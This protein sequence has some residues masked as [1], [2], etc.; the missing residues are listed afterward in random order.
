[1]SDAGEETRFAVVPPCAADGFPQ[2]CPGWCEYADPPRQA[3]AALASPGVGSTLPGG[4]VLRGEIGRGGMG[5]VFV[6]STASG[7][8]VA[9]KVLA[10][11]LA[12]CRGAHLRFV[13]EARAMSRVDHPNVLRLLDA[14]E[15][16]PCSFFVMEL[17][18]GVDLRDFI[19]EAG[20]YG[21]P[22]RRALTLLEAVCAGVAAIH[23]AEVVH[24]DLKP[25][26]V[27]VDASGRVVICDFGLARPCAPPC[28]FPDGV[29]AGTP[30]FIAPE[31]AEGVQR[32]PR[33]S[34]D[35]Y[36]LGVI[37]YELLAGAP[38]FEADS[39]TQDRGLPHER[40]VLPPRALNSAIPRALDDALVA[41]LDHAP[42]R[43]PT[44]ADLLDI[45][46]GCAV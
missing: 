38:A 12:R 42:R 33:P 23:R 40:P 17:V 9:V 29:L 14:Q 13:G 22:L 11:D 24:L 28:R 46:R 16:G 2:G 34:A 8:P 21:I 18:R 37:A 6:A 43:R 30:G 41:A 32:A 25:S 4:Y 7:M 10:A 3:G 15:G 31:V 35:V 44:A 20:P 39:T 27:L 45:V 19:C 1:V 36:A 26:N 5:R